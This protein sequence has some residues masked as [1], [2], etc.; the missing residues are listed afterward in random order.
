MALIVAAGRGLRVGGGIPKQYRPLGGE[1]VLRRTVRA[2]LRHP[3]IDVVRCVVHPEDRALYGAA[4]HGLPLADP[5]LGRAARQGSVRAGLEACAGAERVLIHDAARPL[6]P[7]GVIDRVL[8]ALDDGADGATPVVPVADTLCRANGEAVARE[9]LHRVQTPQGFRYDAILR[10]HRAACDDLA[11]DDAGL[12][13]AAGLAVALVPGDEAAMKLTDAQDFLRA[14]AWLAG[15]M[16]VRVGTGFDVHA[17][18]P[19]DHVMLCGLRIEHDA[20]VVAHSDGDVGLHA[21][22]DA[23]LGALSEGDIGQHFPPTDARW[24][25]AASDVFLAHAGAL[26]AERGG[27][28]D[29]LDLTIVGER[30]KVGPHRD[31]MR[32]RIA[33]ILGLGEAQVSVKATT[34][35]GLGFTGRREG[36]AAQASATIRLPL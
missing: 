1:P 5:V 16:T 19:G 32:A 13:R 33:A 20:G 22:T 29:H 34:T 35:E 21:L 10:A 36:I 7:A 12:A 31:A 15:A 30:P 18:G 28:I 2:F 14:E 23:I 27:L 3:A 25:G 6:V 17:F 26:V 11:T 8:G 24:R 4:L 9:G